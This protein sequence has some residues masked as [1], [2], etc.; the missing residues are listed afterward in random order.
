MNELIIS[1]RRR[2]RYFNCTNNATITT[3][4]QKPFL[5]LKFP[6]ELVYY[7]STFVNTYENLINLRNTNKLLYDI[8]TK[9]IERQLEKDGFNT[10]SLLSETRSLCSSDSKSLNNAKSSNNQ[11]L[12]I[13]RI[14]DYLDRTMK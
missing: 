4:K 7:I 1:R 12:S 3:I 2:R 6:V 5:L 9:Y 8:A 13:S 11:I 10:I 14:G